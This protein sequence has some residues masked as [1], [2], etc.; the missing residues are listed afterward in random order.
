MNKR[1]SSTP[2]LKDVADLAGVSI[3]TVSRVLS[4]SPAVR[5]SSETRH[6]ILDAA[7][8]LSYQPNAM[9]RGL[10]TRQTHT[11]ALFIPE[12]GNPSIAEIIR[13]VEIG[14][15]EMG[16]SAFISH[17]NQRAI[18][19]QLY[20]LWLRE[21]RFDGLILACTRVADTI[22]ES[23]TRSG[24]PFVLA[25]RRDSSTQQH[26][27]IDDAAS[28]RLAVEHLIQ[29][30]HR[31]IAHLA[32]RLIFDTA[33]RRY[34]GYRQQL[35][36]HHIPYDTALVEE[37]A[38]HT[39]EGYRSAMKRMIER[40]KRPTAVFSGNLMGAVG[41]LR[42]LKDAGLR[43]PEDVSVISPNDT[44]LAEMLD[45][46]LTV[47]VT[48]MKELGRRAAHMV[49]DVVEGKP[50]QA[51]QVLMPEGILVRQSTAPPPGGA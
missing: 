37:C 28:A 7:Q 44:S 46:P 51:P 31:R 29:L 27:T 2:T 32:G 14:A 13:G 41:A 9:A 42:A 12:L 6:R 43:I 23:L 19:E 38:A 50:F 5:V 36:Y 21:R 1:L 11:L 30:G 20:L 17:L 26:V 24:Y 35:D 22:V 8:T 3:P 45:P 33:L 48:P 49:A 25:N 18:D 16:Y 39:W 15:G 40:G 4:E 34:Q 10:R 47:V